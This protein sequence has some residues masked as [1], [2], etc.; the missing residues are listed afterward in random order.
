METIRRENKW[1]TIMN[2]IPVSDPSCDDLC[3]AFLPP[4]LILDL[5]VGRVEN[6]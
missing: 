5:A 2:L 4:S 1:K 6:R 3:I